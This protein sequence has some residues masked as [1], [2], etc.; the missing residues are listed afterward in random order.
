MTSVSTPTATILVIDDDPQE[1]QDL[2]DT[3]SSLC[4][5]VITAND[6]EQALAALGATPVDVIV[7]DLFMP[8]LDGFQLLR[9][10]LDRGDL[11]PAIVL[12]GLG[13]IE[14]AITI[15]H[16]LR[17]FWFME[18]P[19]QTSVL[20][21]L[22]DR[23]ITHRN[24]SREA[25]RL[26]RELSYRGVLGEMIGNSGPMQQVFSLIQQVAPTTASVLITGES[27]TGKE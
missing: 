2:A 3:I 12:T 4:Y 13:S 23:A 10:L 24:T 25:E 19:A 11:T 1:R 21:A 15:V 22:L 7:T 20:S 9:T 14:R 17:A 5:G 16:D 6:G 27:G 26:Q 18:K 8:R